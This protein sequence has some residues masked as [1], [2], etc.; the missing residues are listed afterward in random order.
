M[1]Q[2]IKFIEIN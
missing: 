2:I 1:L